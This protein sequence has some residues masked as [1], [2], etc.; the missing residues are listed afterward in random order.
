MERQRAKEMIN[1]YKYSP[2]LVFRKM[3][4]RFIWESKIPKILFT[5]DDGPNPSTTTRILNELS[6]QNVKAVFFCVGENIK[7]Y[8]SLVN[9]ILSEGHT[10]ANHTLQHTKLTGLNNS[11]I[12]RS[13]AE[14]NNFMKNSFGIEIKYFRPPYGRFT[15]GLN[16][17][18]SGLG[19]Q[20]VMWSLLTYDYKNDINIVKFALNNYLSSNSII[21]FHDSKKSGDIIVD[22]IRFAV[23][24]INKKGYSIGTPAE[25]LK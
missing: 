9:D 16:K 5:F 23:D 2:P 13:L 10:I 24:K 12:E 1:S 8:K 18:L 11:E 25:C 14:V 21:V 3:F 15:I 4:N 6:E 19:M 22:S 7:K 17:I 20:N